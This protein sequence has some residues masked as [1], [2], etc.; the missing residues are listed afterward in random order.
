[1]MKTT[2]HI[3]HSAG[4][5]VLR[6]ALLQSTTNLNTVPPSWINVA[7]SRNPYDTPVTDP[8]RFFRL[9]KS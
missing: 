2:G 6:S 9:I 5:N 4:E 7:G 1:M 8:H 3:T